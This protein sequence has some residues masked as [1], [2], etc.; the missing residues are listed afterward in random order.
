MLQSEV[1]VPIPRNWSEEL[2][3]EWLHL[4]GYLT[5]VG[6]AVGVGSGGGR[7]EADVVG[8]KISETNEEGKILEIYHVE[9]GELGGNHTRNVQSLKEKFSM[10][11]VEEVCERFK[12]RVAF[13]GQVQYEK[14]YIDIWAT[15]TKASKLTNDNEI[16]QQGIRVWTLKDLFREVFL[17]IKEWVPSYRQK[18]TGATL[19][20]S[21]WMLKLLES[22]R[23]WKLLNIDVN[24]TTN[25]LAS[26]KP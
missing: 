21:Y 7:K 12:K 16:R 15:V 11:R 25:T 6:I 14:V 9:V 22:L 23:E 18:S 3:S 20:E 5:E 24:R 26:N 13:T 17:A 19:P 1:I 2:I 4:R 8:V 10:T